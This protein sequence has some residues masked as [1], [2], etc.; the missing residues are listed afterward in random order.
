MARNE[1]IGTTVTCDRCGTTTHVPDTSEYDAWRKCRD[2]GWG[3]ITAPNGDALEW[4]PECVGKFSALA[5]G[6]ELR[7]AR[8]PKAPESV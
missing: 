5:K 2:I 6:A 4:C 3:A 1:T 8:K 7:T